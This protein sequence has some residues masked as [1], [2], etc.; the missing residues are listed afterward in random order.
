MVGGKSLTKKAEEGSIQWKRRQEG[1]RA[2][3]D[4]QGV[5]ATAQIPLQQNL[6]WEQS[7]STALSYFILESTL[8]VIPAMLPLGFPSTQTTAHGRN[9]PTANSVWMRLP[10]HLFLWGT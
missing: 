3:K 6:L 2:H 8:T 9:A 10:A 1:V 7:C 4:I 5:G